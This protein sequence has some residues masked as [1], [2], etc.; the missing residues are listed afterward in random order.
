MYSVSLLFVLLFRVVMLMISCPS[1]CLW[2]A[3]CSTAVV[4]TDSSAMSP[5]SG[6]RRM[7]VKEMAGA[8]C[9]DHRVHLAWRL[10]MSCLQHLMS[11][12]R[13]RKSFFWRSPR[14]SKA[15]KIGMQFSVVVLWMQFIVSPTWSLWPLK[16][17]LLHLQ[18][19]CDA[20]VGLAVEVDDR[21]LER[22]TSAVADA[23][24]LG[25]GNFHEGRAVSSNG[26]AAGT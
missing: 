19:G 11:S 5:S 3:V 20:G 22:S 23:S 21:V 18:L 6:E 8:V 4:S 25:N 7:T 26:K 24:S 16:F 2:V 17:C 10:S 13:A 14:S 12:S 15:L 9:A 1:S